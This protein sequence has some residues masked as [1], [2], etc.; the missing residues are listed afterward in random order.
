MPK[1]PS[2]AIPAPSLSRGGYYALVAG[3]A[4]LVVGCD[5]APVAAYGGP[6]PAVPTIQTPETADA[7]ATAA[8]TGASARATAP[9][10]GSAIPAY[11]APPPPPPNTTR[12]Q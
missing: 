1:A 11:G 10:P 12:K 9:P 2:A 5:N 8:D 3:A 6:P 7:G 4:V